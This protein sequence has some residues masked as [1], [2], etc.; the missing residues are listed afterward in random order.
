VLDLSPISVAF[1]A[2]SGFPEDRTVCLALLDV[3][4]GHNPLRDATHLR[5]L[6][7]CRDWFER[8]P[9]D[10]NSFWAEDEPRCL[11]D[12]I[13]VLQIAPCIWGSATSQEL[14]DAAKNLR[15]GAKVA[16]LIGKDTQAGR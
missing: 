12:R 6:V 2:L 1:C 3:E 4:A 5:I 9:Q 13:H 10:T 11:D 15:F 14:L 8:K 7:R 16:N